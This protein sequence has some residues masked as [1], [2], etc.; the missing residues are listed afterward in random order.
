[1]LKDLCSESDSLRKSWEGAIDKLETEM[2][3]FHLETENVDGEKV[4]TG[5]WVKHGGSTTISSFPNDKTFAPY[6][7]GVSALAEVKSDDVAVDSYALTA[8]GNGSGYV[9]LIS[10]D[11]NNPDF[12]SLPISLHVIRVSERWLKER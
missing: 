7:A 1:M 11:G 12:S 8:V 10:N 9:T 4:P 3:S 2:V 5:R 6:T